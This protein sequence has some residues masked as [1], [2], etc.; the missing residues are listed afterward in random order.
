MWSV[1]VG[2]YLMGVGTLGIDVGF[3]SHHASTPDKFE[4][5]GQGGALGVEKL[6]SADADSE[7]PRRLPHGTYVLHRPGCSQAKDQLLCKGQ[8]WQGVRRRIASR[9]TP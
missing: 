9:H 2:R 6:N 1:M 8:R 4:C 7:T 5:I 3:I